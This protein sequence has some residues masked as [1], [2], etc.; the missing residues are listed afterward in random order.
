MDDMHGTEA[1]R[2]A[3]LAARERGTP[4]RIERHGLED[5]SAHSRG[6][7][8]DVSPE[9]VLLQQITE[10]VDLDGFEVLRLED[11]T[12]L[13]TEWRASRF[14]QRALELKDQRP[15]RP[16]GP[17][18]LAGMREAVTSANAAYPLIVVQ[19]EATLPDELSIGRIREETW[20]GFRLHWMNTTAGWEWDDELYQWSAITR[21]E[22]GNEYETTLAMVAEADGARPPEHPDDG[23]D[24]DD[25]E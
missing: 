15:K 4:L 1:L 18:D 14:L 9:L 19:R 13:E 21:L 25:D 24:P 3:L 10:R 17:I 12:G 11:V 22:F 7:V 6:I 8:V 2:Q 23:I 16:A 5:A 20:A